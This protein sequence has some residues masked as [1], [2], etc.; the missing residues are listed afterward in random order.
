MLKHRLITACVLILVLGSAVFWS[1][2]YA[3]IIFTALGVLLTIAA[4]R[5]Y[6]QLTARLD[7]PGYPLLT[8]AAGVAQ[9]AGLGIVGFQHAV[10][11]V[12]QDGHWLSRIV[13]RLPLQ[14]EDLQVR[15]NAQMDLVATG[16]MILFL[17]A[18]FIHVFREADF[19]RG[20]RNLLVSLAGYVYLCWTLSFLIRTYYFLSALDA[21]A[22]LGPFLLFF[23]VMVTKFGD[24]G[25]YTL[26]KLSAGRKNGNHKL[27]P[28]LSPKKSWEGLLGSFIFSVIVGLGLLAW[29]HEPAAEGFA[30]TE[31]AVHARTITGD[32]KVLLNL[33]LTVVLGVLLAGVGLIGDLAESVLKRA[34]E[35]KD[36]GSVLP[37]MGGAL[38]ALDSLI[39]IAPAFYF[40]LTLMVR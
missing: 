27:V 4:L 18:A 12:E 20:I 40:Y 11:R 37:G 2:P 30:F 1:S 35:I 13:S 31:M 32:T 36:S 29:K 17:F 26:G 25:G 33:P 19:K 6:F 34:A 38:D 7:L 8:M 23:V 24:V 15:L 9:V 16:V 39:F 10:Y 21:N 14:Q 22:G 28:R 5:E 3:G